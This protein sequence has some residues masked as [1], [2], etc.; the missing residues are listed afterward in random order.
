MR[1]PENRTGV[2]ESCGEGIPI[3]RI[4]EV[5]RHPVQGQRATRNPAIFT[6]DVSHGGNE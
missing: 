1:E 3:R 4:W 6:V 2:L 5:I